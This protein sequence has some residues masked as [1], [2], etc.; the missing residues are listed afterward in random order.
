MFQQLPPFP[1]PEREQGGCVPR[2]IGGSAALASQTGEG[3]VRI[4]YTP[5]MPR[6][7]DDQAL[8]LSLSSSLLG[9]WGVPLRISTQ[10]VR[11]DRPMPAATF[12]RQAPDKNCK[13][14]LN[15]QAR[16]ELD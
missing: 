15:D 4:I 10:R 14:S 8:L 16:Q 9:G 6:Y 3:C 11:I 5:F 1:F 2:R 13:A 12:G 7:I